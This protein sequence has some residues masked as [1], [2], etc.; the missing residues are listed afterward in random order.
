MSPNR[1]VT[2]FTKRTL[3]VIKHDQTAA[4][5]AQFPQAANSSSGV[6][7]LKVPMRC[8]SPPEELATWWNHELTAS[9]VSRKGVDPCK[10]AR[11]D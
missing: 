10:R 4:P 11:G 8:S 6:A 1:I 7:E 3:L 2:D 9:P 5:K